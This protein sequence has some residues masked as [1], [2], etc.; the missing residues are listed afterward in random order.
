MLHSRRGEKGVDTW[1]R[2]AKL[3][4]G[5]TN[6]LNLELVVENGSTDECRNKGSDHLDDE[7]VPRRDMSVVG[8]FE[9]TG[10]GERLRT[11]DVM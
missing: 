3:G 2:E 4:G 10:K 7:R 6:V 1:T 11:G 9:I 5:S 8:E